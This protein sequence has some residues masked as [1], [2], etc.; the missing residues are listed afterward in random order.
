LNKPYHQG[1]KLNK[2]GSSVTNVVAGL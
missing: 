1:T 2:D